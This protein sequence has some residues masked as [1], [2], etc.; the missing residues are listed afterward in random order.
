MVKTEKDMVSW[1]SLLS[2]PSSIQNAYLSHGKPSSIWFYGLLFIIGYAQQANNV[3][4]EVPVGRFKVES[5]T[6]AASDILEA[7]LWL[8]SS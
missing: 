3:P 1:G 2:F 8:R 7:D 5:P 6:E 4:G